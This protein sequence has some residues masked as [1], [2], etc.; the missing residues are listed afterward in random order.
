MKKIIARTL[1]VFTAFI[2]YS[3]IEPDHFIVTTRLAAP[4]ITIPV[5]PG[6]GYIWIEGEWFWNG[7]GYAWR[8]GYWTRP[9]RGNHYV[10]GGWKP[11]KHGWY[12][13]QGQWRR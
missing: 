10:P 9:T 2:L 5:S 8:N 12:W 11:K 1:I 3:C 7:N 13:R 4:V 6:D